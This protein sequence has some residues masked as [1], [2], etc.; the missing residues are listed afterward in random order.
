VTF[1]CEVG[2]KAK[3]GLKEAKDLA[4]E[5]LLIQVGGKP[6]VEIGAKARQGQTFKAVADEYLK[7]LRTRVTNGELRQS[8]LDAIERQLI[9]KE[10]TKKV[11]WKPLH[12]LNIA[13]IDRATVAARLRK[14]ADQHGPGAA[15]Q[16]RASLSTLFAWTI[17]KASV[18]P[19]PW[20]ARTARARVRSASAP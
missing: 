9:G 6:L 19:I 7:V 10:R 14:I 4:K 1:K 15:D 8:S 16:S 3:I 20:R 12:S 11:H 18:T 2:E 5:A 13:S 17:G